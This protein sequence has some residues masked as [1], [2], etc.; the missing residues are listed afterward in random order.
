MKMKM[1]T[2]KRSHRYSTNRPRPRHE[3]KYSEYKMCLSMMIFIRIK[4]TLKA[5][6]CQRH[7]LF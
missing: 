6:F 2:K 7:T 5:Y 1:D 3:H 4:D